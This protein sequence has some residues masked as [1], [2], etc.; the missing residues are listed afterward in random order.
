MVSCRQQRPNWNG[1][2]KYKANMVVP[3]RE[4]M[5][6]LWRL[7]PSAV[8]QSVTDVPGDVH[9]TVLHA[10]P[11]AMDPVFL[12]SA[13]PDC[14][15]SFPP[16]PHLFQFKV[17]RVLS[18]ESD[19][20]LWF[21]QLFFDL[22]WP[23]RLFSAVQTFH[24]LGNRWGGGGGGDLMD[25]SEEILFQS[26]LREAFVNKLSWARTSTLTL[27]INISSADHG[28]AH[29]PR[30]PEGFREAVVVHDMREPCVF[31]SPD[32]RQKDSSGPTRKP[33][34]LRAWTSVT[35]K[36]KFGP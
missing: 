24:L 31:P 13:F 5:C 18:S 14:S 19:F 12:I 15:T 30:C 10:S 11:T 20:Y 29:P 35:H 9:N 4:G 33:V 1:F 27:S 17:T 22:I 3:R 16:S 25:K 32:S 28:V 7:S 26:S 21:D 36:D 23:S 2:F 8:S 6:R 34:L